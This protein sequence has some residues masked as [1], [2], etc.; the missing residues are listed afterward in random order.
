MFRSMSTLVHIA[1]GVHSAAS[2]SSLQCPVLLTDVPVACIQAAMQPAYDAANIQ[3]G[4]GCFQRM[5][6]G[7]D[8]HIQAHCNDMFAAATGVRS[9]HVALTHSVCKLCPVSRPSAVCTST[10]CVLREAVHN[11]GCGDPRA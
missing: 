2:L 6:Q 5:K 8:A 9:P 4:T 11:A 3:H 7:M 10:A 1:D